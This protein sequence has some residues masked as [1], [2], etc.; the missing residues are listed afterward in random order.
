M[1]LF[2]GKRGA[3]VTTDIADKGK[4]WFFISL[5]RSP[6]TPPPILQTQEWVVQVAEPKKVFPILFRVKLINY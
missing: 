3:K 4:Q 2:A 5:P 6:P 1:S